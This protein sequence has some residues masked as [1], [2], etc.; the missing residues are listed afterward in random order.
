MEQQNQL[1]IPPYLL[2]TRLIILVSASKRLHRRVTKLLDG[3]KGEKGGVLRS[4]LV[5]SS[6]TQFANFMN[7]NSLA[8]M[9]Y[10]LS[11]LL[12]LIDCGLQSGHQGF[13]RAIHDVLTHVNAEQ[14]HPS[15]QY[16]YVNTVEEIECHVFDEAEIIIKLL[17]SNNI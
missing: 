17:N 16:I 11:E 3:P 10:P 14:V 8:L 15:P 1:I 12:I 7:I 13:Y 2:G 9:T 5:I 4:L 6:P